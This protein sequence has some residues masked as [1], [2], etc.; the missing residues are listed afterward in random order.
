MESDELRRKMKGVISVCVTPF[1][2]NYEVDVEGVKR[3]AEFLVEQGVDGLIACGSVG[4]FSS[5]SLEEFRIVV[6]TTVEAVGGRKPVIAGASHS[7]TH[8]CMKLAKISEQAGADG[9]MTVPPYYLKPTWEGVFKHYR[10]LSESI[11]IGMTVYN[12]PGFSKVNITPQQCLELVEGMDKIVAIKETSGDC[13]QFF[14]TL[15]LCKGKAQII[16]G[17]EVLAFFGLACGSPGYISSIADF[18]PRLAIE[19]YQAFEE[20]DIERAKR[21]NEKIAPY[22]SLMAQALQK[23]GVP[24]MIPFAK[25]AMKLLEMPAGPV[26]PPLTQCTPDEKERL[27]SIL[28]DWELL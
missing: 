16:M 2:E 15:R 22:N 18:A 20:K 24:K 25:E 6:K 8:E 9:I 10:M 4:E 3:N 1:K 13:A 5:L 17:R 12:N 19:L 14:E 7:G 26:R 11:N 28:R 21:I 23:E 27:V